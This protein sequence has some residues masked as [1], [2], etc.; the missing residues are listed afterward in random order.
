MG[1]GVLP[2]VFTKGD[3]IKSLGLDGSERYDIS[4]IRNVRPGCLL[5]VKATKDNGETVSFQVTVKLNSDVEVQYYIHGGI[6][7]FVLRKII[8]EH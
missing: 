8:E 2:L 3:D 5:T 4:G 6:L 1:M 7:P